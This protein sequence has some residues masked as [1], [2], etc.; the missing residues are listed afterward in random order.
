MLKQQYATNSTI[1]FTDISRYGDAFNH[2]TG[3]NKSGTA[4]VISD[5]YVV[6]MREILNRVGAPST[7]LSNKVNEARRAGGYIKAVLDVLYTG[8]LN[9][10][11][12]SGLIKAIDMSATVKGYTTNGGNGGN[13]GLNDGNAFATDVASGLY[14]G[15]GGTTFNSYAYNG[16]SKMIPFRFSKNL[17]KLM[18][19][20]SFQRY[21]I[22]QTNRTSDFFNVTEVT[23]SYP[24]TY[25]RKGTEPGKL[26]TTDANGKEI[27]V[28]KGSAEFM[29]LTE[30]GDCFTLGIKVPS[31]MQKCSKMIQ[32]CLTGQADGV[33]QCQTYM[34]TAFFA[35]AGQK[36]VDDMNPAIALDLLRSFGFAKKTKTNKELGADLVVV[37]SAQ[38]WIVTLHRDHQASSSGPAGNKLTSTEIDQIANEKGLLAYLDMVSQKINSS[39]AILNPGFSGKK[40]TQNAAAFTGTTFHKYGMLPKE[41]VQGRTA[42]SLSSIVH[43]QNQVLSQRNLL[44]VDPC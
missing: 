39:P 41:A 28:Q 8:S 27:E 35:K 25:F 22:A 7:D 31:E 4:N 18:L 30:A 24:E 43:I 19:E 36:E 32:D 34:N 11:D 37:D 29:K 16:D 12:M 14:N 2:E 38:E 10:R 42:P 3:Q 6:A 17:L 44:S 1:Q 20:T 33:K 23:G 9:T 13:A 26:F 5:D 21:K 40:P 15:I